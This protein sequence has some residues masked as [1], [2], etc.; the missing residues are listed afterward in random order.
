MKKTLRAFRSKS[1]VKITFV[2]NTEQVNGVGVGFMVAGARPAKLDTVP[3]QFW[4]RWRSLC[5]ILKIYILLSY[6]YLLLINIVYKELTDLRAARVVGV[7]VIILLE[8]SQSYRLLPTA[9]F[10]SDAPDVFLY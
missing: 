8:D 6:A 2:T 9:F 5:V 3:R 7:K 1:C 10:I 4:Q